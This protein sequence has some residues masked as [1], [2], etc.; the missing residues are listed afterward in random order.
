MLAGLHLS[1][2]FSCGV[3]S[4]WVEQAESCR[5]RIFDFR[6]VCFREKGTL[7]YPSFAQ[8]QQQ[9]QL[10]RAALNAE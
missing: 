6:P 2:H 4:Y 1:P 7:M 3:A 5:N 10:E 8:S 9:Q